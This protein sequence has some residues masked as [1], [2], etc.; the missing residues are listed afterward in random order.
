MQVGLSAASPDLLDILTSYTGGS[1]LQK[2]E[3]VRRLWKGG[4]IAL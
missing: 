2:D 1:H 4:H 3:P